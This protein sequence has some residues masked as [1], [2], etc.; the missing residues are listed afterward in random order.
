MG[1]LTIGNKQHSACCPISEQMAVK[2]AA[3][4]GVVV[5]VVACQ[6]PFRTE[7][8]QDGRA[9]LTRCTVQ[10]GNTE[11]VGGTAD[12]AVVTG[13]DGRLTF[14][15]GGDGRRHGTGCAGKDDGSDGETHGDF[16]EDERSFLR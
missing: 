1:G 15:Q 5:A 4:V 6:Q 8:A 14:D 10:V 3:S 2:L 12:R 13:A 11:H 16:G 7:E 9:R